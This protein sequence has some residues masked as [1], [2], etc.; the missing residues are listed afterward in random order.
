MLKFFFGR[1]GLG[2]YLANLLALLMLVL[3]VVKA[4]KSDIHLGHASLFLFY[5]YFFFNVLRF[6]PWYGRDKADVGL[7]FHF[8][9]NLVPLAYISLLAFGLKYLSVGEAW[10]MCFAL[11][12]LPLHYAAWVL[13][14]FHLRDK[15]SLPVGYFSQ[16][17]YLSK[18]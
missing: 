15:S 2:M 16:N 1:H 17:R 7:R 4:F 12:T 11:L 6:Y 9:R 3:L 10:L 18:E 5:S 13:I 8:Q 14:V